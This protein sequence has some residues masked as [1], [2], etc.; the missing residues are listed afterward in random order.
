MVEY[1]RLEYGNKRM[2]TIP[3]C[4]ATPIVLDTQI[5]SIVDYPT[6]AGTSVLSSTSVLKVPAP[7]TKIVPTTSMATSSAPDAGQKFLLMRI[8]I[9]HSV[10]DPPEIVLAE[11]IL[12]VAA[13]LFSTQPKIS[14]DLFVDHSPERDD[15]EGDDDADDRS[16]KQSER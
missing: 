15:V 7:T 11:P 16:E 14:I 13:E 8:T 10:L 2:T 3:Q 9:P 6:R 4:Q 12:L 5:L 1:T